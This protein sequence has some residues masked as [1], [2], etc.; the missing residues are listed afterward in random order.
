MPSK[1]FNQAGTIKQGSESSERNYE[2][3]KSILP[4]KI[5]GNIST[6]QIVKLKTVETL[7]QQSSDEQEYHT[8]K[9]M[10]AVD[11]GKYKKVTTNT[12]STNSNHTLQTLDKVNV[13]GSKFETA[14]VPQ[15]LND[16]IFG[17]SETYQMYEFAGQNPSTIKSKLKS[18]LM[19]KDVYKE[20]I[21]NSTEINSKI[22]KPILGNGNMRE[23]S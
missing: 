13:K 23:N 18:Q 9:E 3:L 7:H 17:N 1:K 22:L 20:M 16:G 11:K 2:P 6:K 5:N 14:S 8:A 4:E 19:Q 12:L 21:I 15:L 10:S